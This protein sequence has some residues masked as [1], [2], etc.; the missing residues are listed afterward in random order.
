MDGDH[1][2]WRKILCV[3]GGGVLEPFLLILQLKAIVRFG[4]QLSV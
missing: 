4:T 2:V 1:S 3:C